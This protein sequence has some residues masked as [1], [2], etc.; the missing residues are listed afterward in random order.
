MPTSR[1]YS[2]MAASMVIYLF[3]NQTQVGWLYVVAALLLG[4]VLAGWWMN[5]G[6]LGHLEGNRQIGDGQDREFYETETI[7]ITLTLRKRAGGTTHHL[8]VREECPLAAPDSPTQSMQLFIPSLSKQ[9]AVQFTY[10]V[11][12]DRRGVHL[13]P[14]NRS[15]SRA[16]FGFFRREGKLHIKTSVLVYPEVRPLQRFAF[17]ERTLNAQIARPR[18]GVGYEVMGVRPYRAGDSPRHI[19]WRSVARTGVLISKEF[20]DEAQPGLTLVIDLFEHPYPP[21]RSKHTSFEWA[22]KAAASIGDYA[23]HKGYRLH[24]LSDDEATPA[25]RGVID[26]RALLE[27]L[28]RVQPQGKRPLEQVIGAQAVQAFVVVI[29]PWPEPT[30]IQPLITLRQQGANVMAVVMAAHSFPKAGSDS[31]GLCEPL[32]SADIEVR[33]V[34]FGDD[35]VEQL[36]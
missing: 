22:V 11:T 4:I 21:E 5:R 2:F 15:D 23:Q 18:A 32:R 24:L 12:L 3:G 36:M 29:L 6:V 17:L 30:L 16:P 33:E 14:D 7:D 10:P 19:H 27:Y 20:A 28:A 9:Q 31:S 8:R 25:P 34:V 13:F 1:A 35:W 26:R